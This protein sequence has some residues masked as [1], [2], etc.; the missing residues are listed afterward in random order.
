MIEIR[1]LSPDY[2]DHLI[3]LWEK[4]GLSYRPKGRDSREEI[5]RQMKENPDFFLG[6]FLEGEL[7]GCIIATFDGRKGW[8]NRLTVL[9]EHRRQGIAQVLITGA[10]DALRKRGAEV[11]GI[12]IY[13]DNVPS[14]NL[15]QRMGYLIGEDLLYLSKRDRRE[16]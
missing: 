14:L 7:V 3:S 6:A 16:S 12:L 13:E 10:E 4:A 2:Y 8:I 15:F 5:S 9:P 11:I 1:L